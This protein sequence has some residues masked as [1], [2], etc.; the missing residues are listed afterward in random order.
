MA[1]ILVIEDDQS[2]LNNL[3]L[4]LNAHQVLVA[5]TASEGLE[6]IKSEKPDLILLDLILPDADGVEV[7]KKIKADNESKNI[8]VIVLTNL[9]DEEKLKA[10]ESSGCSQCFI[11]ADWSIDDLVKKIE[12]YL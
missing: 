1:K 12:T 9:T 7:I 6:K 8:P 10:A 11:K 5:K 2:L 4:A 3:V